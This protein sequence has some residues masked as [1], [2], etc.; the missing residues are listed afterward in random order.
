MSQ[1]P[2]LQDTITENWNN[3]LTLFKLSPPKFMQEELNSGTYLLHLSSQISKE[4]FRT[5]RTMTSLLQE[6]LGFKRMKSRER[7]SVNVHST[8]ITSI[9][10]YKISV[11]WNKFGGDV[12]WSFGS[13]ELT[14][15]SA[16][17]FQ[18]SSV[19]KLERFS[20]FLKKYTF[21]IKT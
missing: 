21:S 10:T 6:I 4:L 19:S 16:L 15:S 17:L 3:Y 13:T 1:F 2:L 8:Y 12:A 7:G 5:G 14:L 20:C 9:K 11:K 18:A